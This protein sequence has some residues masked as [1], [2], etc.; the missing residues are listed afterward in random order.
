[1]GYDPFY[2]AVLCDEGTYKS[3]ERSL[4]TQKQIDMADHGYLQGDWCFFQPF[5]AWL[6]EPATA[7]FVHA[8]S[9]E[10]GVPFLHYWISQEDIGYCL[11]QEPQK[12]YRSP[13]DCWGFNIIVNGDEVASV[14]LPLDME[15]WEDG[16]LSSL[17]EGLNRANPE[18]F[19]HFGLEDTVLQSLNELLTSE[20]IIARVEETDMLAVAT[21]MQHLL[22]LAPVFYAGHT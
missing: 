13:G 5:D 9:A 20:A 18:Q 1:M 7:Q 10:H 12:V 2:G 3:I 8:L 6:L 22:G 14:T 16:F 17:N 19:A 21:D 15:S 4:A 11:D